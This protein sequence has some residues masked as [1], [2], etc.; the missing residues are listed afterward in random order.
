MI[1]KK[2]VEHIASLARIELTAGEE[3]K[4]EKELSAILEFVEK[5]NEVDT[6]GIEPMS[7][8]TN[9]QNVT[10]EDDQ[11]DKSLEERAIELLKAT[12]DKKNGWIK[13]RAI[14]E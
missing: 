10:R 9:L 1:A 2:D 7:G 14:F 13:V 11:I 12:P 8:G 6:A 4:F 5:L 3:K